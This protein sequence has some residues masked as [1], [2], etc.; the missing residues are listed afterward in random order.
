MIDQNTFVTT[1]SKSLVEKMPEIKDD[2]FN[3]ELEILFKMRNWQ[4]KENLTIEDAFRTV[5]RDFDGEL[6]RLDL[7]LFIIEIF[8]MEEKLLNEARINRLFKLMD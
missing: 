4:K 1:I 6:S 2:D 8:K 7:K 3:W 5:D